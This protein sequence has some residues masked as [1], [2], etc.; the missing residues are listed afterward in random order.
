MKIITTLLILAASASVIAQKA[1][2]TKAKLAPPGKTTVVKSIPRL[3]VA[4]FATKAKLWDRRDVTVVGPIRGMKV[5]TDVKGAKSTTFEIASEDGKARVNIFMKGAFDAKLAM[6]D[7]VVAIATGSYAWEK[8]LGKL[9]IKNELDCSIVKGKPYGVTK[10]SLGVKRL[11][12]A[13]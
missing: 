2:A 4:V 8:K 6:R 7:G 11:S 10:G 9:V 1:P 5:K 13:L 12:A 3:P